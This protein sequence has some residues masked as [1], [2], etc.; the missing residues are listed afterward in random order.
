MHAYL[1]EDQTQADANTRQMV[2]V[3]QQTYTRMAAAGKLTGEQVQLATDASQE[4]VAKLTRELREPAG[5]PGGPA[6]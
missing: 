2:R 1:I 4:S 5:V 6:H 3:C